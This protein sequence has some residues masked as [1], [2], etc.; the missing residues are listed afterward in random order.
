MV[1][2]KL[3]SGNLRRERSEWLVDAGAADPVLIRF[4]RRTAAALTVVLSPDDYQPD[5]EL[6][7]AREVARALGGEVVARAPSK[8][9]PGVVY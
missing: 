9:M 6:W 3:P 4:A 2:V 7:L 8:L 1:L 5:A